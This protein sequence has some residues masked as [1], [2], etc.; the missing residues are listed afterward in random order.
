MR[1]GSWIW[2][3]NTTALLDELERLSGA[4]LDLGEIT[5]LVAAIAE[6]DGDAEPE[7]WA[8]QTFEGTNTIYAEFAIDQGT[9]VLRVKLDA[10]DDSAREAEVLIAVMQSSF[11]HPRNPHQ[12]V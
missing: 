5:Y 6:P 4:S 3:A 11:L 7:R 8:S 1:V 2:R 10:A 12:R 9:E